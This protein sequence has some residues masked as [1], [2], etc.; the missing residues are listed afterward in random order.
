MK[1]GPSYGI[2]GGED[3]NC[4]VCFSPDLAPFGYYSYRGK[5]RRRWRCRVCG[6]TTTKPLP[7]RPYKKKRKKRGS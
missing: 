4:P 5:V 3:M 6:A 1:S 2:I 7:R